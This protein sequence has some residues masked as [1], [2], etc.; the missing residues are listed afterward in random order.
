ML[1]LVFHDCWSNWFDYWSNQFR[2]TP[3]HG[4]P[5]GC[6]NPSS[7]HGL[8]VGWLLAL[9]TLLPSVCEWSLD[10]RN[11]LGNREFRAFWGLRYHAWWHGG[12]CSFGTRRLS[13]TVTSISP[14]SIGWF[15]RLASPILAHW[16]G[17]TVFRPQTFLLDPDKSFSFKYKNKYAINK[18]WHSFFFNTHIIP[19]LA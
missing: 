18:E 14:W 19:K 16:L 8:P 2:V 7:S 15:W 3:C 12:I 1:Q 9:K 10:H 13:A 6:L 5:L 4:L 11:H 17:W